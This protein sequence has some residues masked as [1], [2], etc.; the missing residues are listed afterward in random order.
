MTADNHEAV[1]PSLF[2]ET[3]VIAEGEQSPGYRPI[4]STRSIDSDGRLLD[5]LD[6]G[7][8]IYKVD[9][10]PIGAET[11]LRALRENFGSASDPDIT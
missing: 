7:I 3:T 8:V 9:S 11:V 10:P 6:L 1:P 4:Y 2:D 5:V